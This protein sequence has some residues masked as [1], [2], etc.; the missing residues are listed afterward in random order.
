MSSFTDARIIAR[1]CVGAVLFAAAGLVAMPVP[2][3]DQAALARAVQNPVADLV[4]LPFQNNTDFEYGPER[5]TQ[6]VTNI[7]PVIP[8]KLGDEWNL[9]TRTIIPVVSQPGFTPGQD[10]ETGLGD[11]SLTAF[12]SPRQP[13]SLIWGAGPAVVLPTSTDDRL[14]AD[15]WAAGPSLV[16]L[17]MP[18]HWVIGSLFSN[19]WDIDGDTAINLFTWQYFINYNMAGGWYLTSSPINTAN[20]EAA[21]GE[22]WTVPVGGGVG[23]IFQIGQQPMN[24]QVQSFYNLESPEGVGDWSLRLQLQFMFPR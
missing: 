13:G 24:A 12:L 6:N 5:D 20:W 22:E 23:R 10:R 2:A 15:A 9:I 19:V 14:G 3:A 17:T 16:L 18:G 21:S 4:S 1:S 11:T 7:Q 8:F